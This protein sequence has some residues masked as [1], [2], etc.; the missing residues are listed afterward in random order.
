MSLSDPTAA[1][2]VM[3]APPRPDVPLATLTRTRERVL[4]AEVAQPQAGQVLVVISVRRPYQSAASLIFC[5]ASLLPHD[6]ST[7]A[8]DK[9]ANIA[10]TSELVGATNKLRAMARAVR[11]RSY[12]A[13]AASCSLFGDL[14]ACIAIRRVSKSSVMSKGAP[15][16]VGKAHRSDAPPTQLG[17]A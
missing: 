13:I 12:A 9:V 7:L 15:L 2:S 10:S 11:R 14:W 8:F 16:V 6:M 5:D 4:A 17:G 1:S 3:L